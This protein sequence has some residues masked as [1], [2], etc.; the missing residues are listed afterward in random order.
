M[1][2]ELKKENNKIK[3]ENLNLNE[4]CKELKLELNEIKNKYNK[5][6]RKY[7]IDIK[8]YKNWDSDKITDWIISLN[9]DEYGKYENNLRKNLK[10]ESMTGLYLKDLDKNDLHRFGITAFSHKSE[11][12][13]QIRK[14]TSQNNRNNNN[15]I[16]LYNGK[17]EQ[18]YIG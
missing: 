10:N 7:N 16:I 13:K 5:L 17:H 2:N 3:K 18:V 12:I 14:L 11:I 1:N 4:E 6:Y 15:S 9:E 8:N